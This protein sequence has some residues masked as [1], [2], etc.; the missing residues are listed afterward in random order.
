MHARSILSMGGGLAALLTVLAG[1]APAH[2]QV[3]PA[4]ELA[5]YYVSTAPPGKHEEK[6]RQALSQ[7]AS[8]VGLPFATVRV[9]RFGY[10]NP[11]EDLQGPSLVILT[12]TKFLECR[13][14]L[15]QSLVPLFLSHKVGETG[16]YYS[17][18]LVSRRGGEVSDYTDE[19]IRTLYLVHPNSTSGYV[20]PLY[21]L[22]KR[23][24]LDAPSQEAARR[25]GWTVEEKNSHH[26][27]LEA[28]TGEDGDR[29]LGTVGDYET[30]GS[31]YAS[32]TQVLLRYGS[33]PQDVIAVTGSA[34][35]HREAIAD[36]WIK[37][38]RTDEQG[39]LVDDRGQA[40]AL[41]STR[42]DGVVPFDP[43]EHENAFAEIGR[44][45]TAVQ[46]GDANRNVFY[47]PNGSGFWLLIAAVVLGA[48]VGLI[49][50]S[51]HRHVAAVRF[52]LA[53]GLF[54][55]WIW[56][57]LFSRDVGLNGALAFFMVVGVSAFLGTMLRAAARE[58]GLLASPYVSGSEHGGRAIWSEATAGLILAFVLALFY[59]GSGL[60]LFGDFSSLESQAGFQRVVLSVSGLSLLAAAVLEWGWR[61]FR[62]KGSE[63]Y[64][65]KREKKEP[66]GDNP[67]DPGVPEQVP[68]AANVRD[69]F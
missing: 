31:D 56:L 28:L 19:D 61:V 46:A 32:S 25:R 13:E 20:A 66:P 26:A 44:W 45:R 51:R 5:V 2:A 41:A 8:D 16:P 4:G 48:I 30:K 35:R 6:M 21:W 37:A 60:L 29:A 63:R 59:F 15:G 57:F 69:E 23:G 14:I 53:V 58:I 9:E 54:G 62:Q 38:F 1:V 52:G 12:P 10:G 49:L 18:L 68:V 42:L 17:G 67:D 3:E 11:C 55:V 36:W 33:I 64:E 39:N 40:L 24:V 7:I 22:W 34:I 47:N 65:L 27:V 50:G 43:V